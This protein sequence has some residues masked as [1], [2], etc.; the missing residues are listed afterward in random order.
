MSS[1]RRFVAYVYEYQGEQKRE[2]RG[3][4]KVEARNGN[5]MME[6]HMQCP[7]L[8]SEQECVIYGF[9]RQNQDLLGIELGRCS[10]QSEKIDCRLT[11][12]ADSLNGQPVRLDDLNG[13]VIIPEGGGF[14]GTQWDDE[15]LSPMAFKMPKKPEAPIVASTAIEEDVSQEE[16]VPEAGDVSEESERPQEEVRVPTDI[17][18]QS[19]PDEVE[20]PETQ[21]EQEV[22]EVQETKTEKIEQQEEIQEIAPT[23]KSEEIN[24]VDTMTEGGKLREC[25]QCEEEKMPEQPAVGRLEEESLRWIAVGSTEPFWPFED[26]EISDCVK[27]SPNDFRHFHKRDW[28]LKNNRFLLHGY[29][30]FG[31]L[32]LGKIRGSGQC[33]LGVPGVYGQ[34]ERMM[35]NMFG[36][37]HFKCSR[38][39]EL[40]GE[41]GGRGGYWYRLIYPPNFNP[42]NRLR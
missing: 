6:V 27:I 12:D 39:P 32:L 14:Y 22:R 36:F 7:N 24:R 4:V 10:T 34:Q 5:C 13:M 15:N 37:P 23:E 3:F 17:T 29:H 42:G 28:P 41:N 19:E 8:A 31:H 2:N 25:P 21:G 1:Y 40:T 35:A 9:I 33:V 11:A 16:D 26:G 18:E 30:Q 20:E 38:L